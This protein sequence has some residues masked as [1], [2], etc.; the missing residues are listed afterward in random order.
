MLADRSGGCTSSE[1]ATIPGDPE[2]PRV[3]TLMGPRGCMVMSNLSSESCKL[4]SDLLRSLRLDATVQ[5]TDTHL[6]SFENIKISNVK[7]YTF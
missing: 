3:T 5:M 1:R 7:R 2:S 4:D 6:F